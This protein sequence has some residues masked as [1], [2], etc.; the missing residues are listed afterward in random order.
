MINDS[1]IHHLMLYTLMTSPYQSLSKISWIT[2]QKKM[3]GLDAILVP[4][5]MTS[6]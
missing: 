2:M 3:G 5:K 4:V 1:K 6:E